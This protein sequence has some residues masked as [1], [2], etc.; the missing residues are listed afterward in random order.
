MTRFSYN[1]HILE[2]KV[3]SILQNKDDEGLHLQDGKLSGSKWE[4]ADQEEADY[5][6]CQGSDIACTKN[7]QSIP[8]THCWT[9]TAIS[10]GLLHRACA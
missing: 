9:R 10:F 2:I 8:S 5:E 4:Q 7:K 6:A 1:R 3:H